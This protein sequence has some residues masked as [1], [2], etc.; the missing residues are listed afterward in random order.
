VGAKTSTGQAVL[1]EA[2]AQHLERRLSVPIERRLNLGDTLLA[3]QALLTGI[4]DLYPE[5]SGLALTIIFKLPHE[6]DPAIVF[7]R[8]RN[9]YR[10]RCAV[11]WLERLGSNG[12]FA[13]IVR[14]ADAR[15]P[16]LATLSDAVSYAP[17]WKLG[18]P[19]EFL[20][21]PA[22]FRRLMS[23]YALP[24]AAGP[25]T[26]EPGA[27]YTAL[28][29]GE[30]NMVAGSPTDPQLDGPEFA[31]LQDDRGAFAPCQAALAVRTDALERL[32]GLRPALAQLGGKF[33][34]AALR[35]MAHAVQF[36]RRP[37]AEV[38]AAF[39]RE[40]GLTAR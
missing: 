8:V 14:T 6:P 1:A 23:V 36:E 38:A 29:A 21:Q 17:R 2:V 10:V 32:P 19:Q 34:L 27:L 31:V 35:K 12:G 9:E 5:Y 18:L 13:M 24:L 33:P 25:R 7:E 39:L 15:P 20:T 40:A 11:E 16:R 3:H 26:V 22:L 37:A 30:V 4:V 28:A